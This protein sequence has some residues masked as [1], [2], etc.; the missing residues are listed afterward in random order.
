MVYEVELRRI[1]YQAQT[2]FQIDDTNKDIL[3][4][5]LGQL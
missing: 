1:L 5:Y 3:L 4:Q 2:L